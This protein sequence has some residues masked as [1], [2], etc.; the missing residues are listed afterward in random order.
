MA[1]NSQRKG[2]IRGPK[3]PRA[4]GSGGVRR[5][6]LEGKGPTPKAEDRPAHVAAK[7]A[8]SAAKK[9]QSKPVRGGQ[10]PSP[11]GRTTKDGG[12]I[13]LGRNPVLES[14]RTGLPASA[15]HLM[16]TA[17]MDDRVRESIN[18]ATQ[19]GIP[20]MEHPKLELDRMAAGA[21]HQGL[22]LSAKP[23]AY[24]DAGE[25]ISS[26]DLLVALDGI[27]DPRNL[28]AIARSA[29]AF[30]ASGLITGL[31]RSAPVSAAAWRTSAGALA[32]V[33]VAQGNVVTALKSAQKAGYFVVGL[34]AGGTDVLELDAELLRRP[35]VVVVGSEGEGLSRLVQQTCDVIAGIGMAAGQESLN[36]SVAASIALHQVW[37]ARSR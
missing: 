24:S 7:R 2:A 37:A 35:V 9:Q 34:D 10:R 21:I 3:K 31:R 25:L 26:G 33:G 15:L 32:R 19:A 5:R 23:F 12:E 29:A 27:T 30:G 8:K 6:A 28:G 4:V 16:E 22:A 20:L 11:R 18:L 17:D 36:A 1:G 13:I 14:L